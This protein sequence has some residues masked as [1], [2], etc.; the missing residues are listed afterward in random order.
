MRVLEAER[1][2]GKRTMNNLRLELAEM[3]ARCNELQDRLNST[4]LLLH[5]ARRPPSN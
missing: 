5:K 3:D 4:M 2:E 1:A